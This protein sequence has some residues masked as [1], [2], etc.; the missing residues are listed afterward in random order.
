MLNF[1]NASDRIKMLL[2]MLAETVGE[3]TE[4]GTILNIKLIHQD[5]ADMTGLTRET[6]TRVLDKWRRSGEIRILS[7][8]LIQLRPEFETISF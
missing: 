2:L 4:R 8:K 5:I 6:V 3:K 1:H 7:N